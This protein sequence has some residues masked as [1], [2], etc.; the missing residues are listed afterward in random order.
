MTGSGYAITTGASQSLGHL[1]IASGASYSLGSTL[2]VSKQIEINGRLNQTGYIITVAGNDTYAADVRG[3]WDG[4]IYLAGTS[5]YYQCNL[6]TAMGYLHASRELRMAFNLGNI[7]MI[8]TSISGTWMNVRISSWVRSHDDGAVLIHLTVDL[9]DTTASV[10]Y[11]I[12]GLEEGYDYKVMKNNMEISRSQQFS[13]SMVF[14]TIGNSQVDVIAWDP[15]G[16]VR[17]MAPIIMAIGLVAG[18]SAIAIV[19]IGSRLRR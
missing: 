8:P 7:T 14:T 12:T 19:A 10:T 15:F 4:D 5:T 9:T 17:D 18:L 11:N 13:G 16:G 3:T 1:E 6:T 2:N